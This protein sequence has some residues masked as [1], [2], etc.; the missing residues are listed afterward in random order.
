[1]PVDSAPV[2]GAPKNVGVANVMPPKLGARAVVELLTLNQPETLPPELKILD[3]RRK[4]TVAS[5]LQ[6]LTRFQLQVAKSPYATAS[7]ISLLT[8]HLIENSQQLYLSKPDLGAILLV[9]Q[10]FDQLLNSEKFDREAWCL[11][12]QARFPITK[13]ALQDFSFFFAPQNIGRKLLNLITLNLLG[14]ATGQSDQTRQAI[15]RFV[16]TL[17]KKYRNNVSEFNSVCIEMQTWFASQQKHLQK[18]ETKISNIE[19]QSKDTDKSEPTLVGFLNNEVGGRELPELIVDFIYGEWRN[20]LRQV[21][22]Q[23]GEKSANWK[24]QMSLTQSMVKAFEACQ[25]EDGREQYTRFLPSMLKGI[26]GLLVSVSDDNDKL[27]EAFDPVELILNALVRGA[28]PE[29]KLSPVLENK[30]V[31]ND[32]FEVLPVEEKYLAEIAELTEGEWIRIRT[33]ANQYEACRLIVKGVDEA[34]WVFVNN[35]GSKIAKKNRY[36]LAQGV[37]DGVIE[38]MGRGRWID[39]LVNHQFTRLEEL[40]LS[41]KVV[42]E[43]EPVQEPEKVLEAEEEIV[44]DDILS[45]DI[46]LD[47]ALEETESDITEETVES[48]ESA[49]FSLVSQEEQDDSYH[50]GNKEYQQKTDEILADS[51]LSLVTDTV[52]PEPEPDADNESAEDWS[53]YYQEE[54]ALTE[55]E[56]SAAEKAVELLE[57]GAVIN[58]FS[59]K[60]E[61]RCKLA[62]KMTARDK[63]IFVNQLGV[64]VWDTNTQEVV[65]SVAKG[66]VTIIDSGTRFDRAL[67]QVVMN[68]QADKKGG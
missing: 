32:T 23:D 64:K 1:M 35:S 26:K 10:V 61:V 42:A 53:E 49:M 41:L 13:F 8:K 54:Q 5:L 17:N 20:S 3:S 40:R 2:K 4:E 38:L 52:E 18:V 67:E 50:A 12:A 55:E 16:E 60:G 7:V 57:V 45:A 36:A 63:L 25:S 48:D 58:L 6:L 51:E 9:D 14:S 19:K 37:R 43:S 28:T 46:E 21:L 66:T 56:I 29:L 27:E 11:I 24:R 47:K 31:V 33:K 65:E 62:V 39:E 59:E 68:I 34:P 15:A 44:I 30:S 22:R